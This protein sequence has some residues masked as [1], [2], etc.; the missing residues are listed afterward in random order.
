MDDIIPPN[1]TP[2]K[3]CNRCKQ[4]LPFARFYRDRSS[5]DRLHSICK[6]CQNSRPGRPR[7]CK[8]CNDLKL[9]TEYRSY[10]SKVCMSCNE[11]RHQSVLSRTLPRDQRNKSLWAHYGLTQAEYDEMFARQF[12]LCAICGLPPK[13]GQWL[14]V[15][16]CHKTSLVRELLCLHCNHMLGNAKDNPETLMKAAAYLRLHMT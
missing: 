3:R 8:K 2:L 9:P 6:T 16:H 15:D 10:Q 4:S 14:H 7:T 1:T 11:K 13:D 12:G 5:K